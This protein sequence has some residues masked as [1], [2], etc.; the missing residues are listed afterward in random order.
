MHRS[1]QRGP[2]EESKAK[3]ERDDRFI[4]LK[5]FQTT[6]ELLKGLKSTRLGGP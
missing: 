4:D 6:N 2:G 5:A 1:F 3:F